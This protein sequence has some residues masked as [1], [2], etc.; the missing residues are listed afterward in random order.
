MNWVTFLHKIKQNQIFRF[1]VIG[2]L[3]TLVDLA[4]L[5]LLLYLFRYQGIRVYP[6]L[7]S[8]SF[9]I[10]VANSYIFN[11]YWVFSV[12][13]SPTIKESGKFF[14]VNIVGL[15]LNLVVASSTLF[16]LVSIFRN[17]V[18]TIVMANGSALLGTFA[19]AVMNFFLYK[20]FVFK[21]V[22]HE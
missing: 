14:G 19:V 18:S 7:K 10:A 9:I 2:V 3:N 21:S 15:F 20:H 16:F 12:G 5:N 13:T 22:G 11:K 6:I 1:V 4:V 8:I 17:T